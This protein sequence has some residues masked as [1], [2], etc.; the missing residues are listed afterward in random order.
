MFVAVSQL[1]TAFVAPRIAVSA[2]AKVTPMMQLGV[3][4]NSLAAVNSVQSMQNFAYQC[5]PVAGRMGTPAN[6]WSE[7]SI[8]AQDDPS[9]YLEPTTVEGYNYGA[10]RTSNGGYGRFSDYAGT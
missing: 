10:M 5:G 7:A 9:Y 1:L 4:G 6:R 3:D 2:H 8:M